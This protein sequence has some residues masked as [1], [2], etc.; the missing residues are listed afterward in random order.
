MRLPLPFARTAAGVAALLL[1][2]SAPA[3]LRA[4]SECEVAGVER[5]VAVGD[6]HGAYDRFV[7]ILRTAGLLDADL[8]WSGG[9]THLVQLGD[10]VDRGADSRRALDL[11]RRLEKEARAAGGAVHALLGNHE[12]MRMLGDMR[13][14]SP[15]E[16]AAFATPRSEEAR[17]TFLRRVKPERRDRLREEMPL[18]RVEMDLAFGPDGEYGKWLRGHSAMAMING[19]VFLHGGVSPGQATLACDAVNATVRREVAGDLGTV[20][21]EPAESLVTREDGPLW[22]RGLAQEPDAFE[23]AVDG[24]LARQG[25]RAIVIG[26]TV[27]PAGRVAVRF[28]GK[29][30]EI[31]TGMQAGYVAG[32]RAS[33]L[34]IRGGTVSAIYTD[35]REVLTGPAAPAAP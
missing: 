30:F 29:V 22:Y 19:I 10:V 28:Q 3:P 2:L 27:A 5:I 6:V 1:A 34:D 35:R 24:I 13:Y 26:H 7:E 23:P 18:G 31:D 33:A 4:A 8:H 15:G 21:T 9:R 11:L 14:V 12:V 25:A 32:G 17:E 20:R 16:Y